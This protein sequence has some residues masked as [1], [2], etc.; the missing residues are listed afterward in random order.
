MTAAPPCIE[1]ACGASPPARGLSGPPSAQPGRILDHLAA[2]RH[3]AGTAASQSSI[4]LGGGLCGSLAA[5]CSS[6]A[7]FIAYASGSMATGR[8]ASRSPGGYAGCGSHRGHRRHTLGRHGGSNRRSRRGQNHRR[9]RRRLDPH[10]VSSVGG[11]MSDTRA[12]AAST[13]GRAMFSTIVLR[14]PPAQAGPT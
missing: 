11:S 4:S 9:N 7:A 13:Y 12:A 1:I 14:V 10:G 6:A 5:S 3:A 8:S 2:P